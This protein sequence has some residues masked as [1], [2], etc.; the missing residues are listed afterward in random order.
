MQCGPILLGN[1][2]QRAHQRDRA[3][4]PLPH[5]LAISMERMALWT[6]QLHHVRY[7]CASSH[8]IFLTFGVRETHAVLDW[9][10]FDSGAQTTCS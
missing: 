9:L 6:I 5:F 7:R 10:I 4:C 2:L 3:Q 1:K 8:I